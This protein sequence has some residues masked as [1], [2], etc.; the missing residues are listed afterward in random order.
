MNGS[1]EGFTD[2]DPDYTANSSAK[3]TMNNHSKMGI[4]FEILQIQVMSMSVSILVVMTL[5]LTQKRQIKKTVFYN[6]I[7]Q[8]IYAKISNT[9]QPIN[10]CCSSKYSKRLFGWIFS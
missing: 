6:T 3:P 2:R 8:K 9:K 1:D 10:R 5:Q 4:S 7:Y